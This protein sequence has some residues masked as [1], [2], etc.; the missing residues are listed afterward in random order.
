M[1]CIPPGSSFRG[2]L[3]ARILEWVAIFSSRGSS[4]PRDRTHISCLAGEFFWATREALDI[5]IILLK[6]L[7]TQNNVFYP[8][9]S[10]LYFSWSTKTFYETLLWGHA[11]TNN[12]LSLLI[13][14]SWRQTE[15][16]ASS[17]VLSLLLSSYLHGLIF[18]KERKL[19]WSDIDIICLFRNPTWIVIQYLG[20]LWV[21]ESNLMIVLLFS[22]VLNL[23]WPIYIF[24]NVHMC[25]VIQTI[26]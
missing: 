14:M 7:S 21:M 26:S 1:D 4:R 6:N 18:F 17:A 2:I 10:I 24:P 19:N 8:V 23:H 12:F 16:P 25:V 11:A 9:F 22:L 5:D 15:S 13:E 3:Q 20:L